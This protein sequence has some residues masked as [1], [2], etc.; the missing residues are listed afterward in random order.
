M[1]E[2]HLAD[3]ERGSSTGGES[4]QLNGSMLHVVG[5]ISMQAARVVESCTN[6]LE[7]NEDVA[8]LWQFVLVS[9]AV[10]YCDEHK[11]QLIKALEALQPVQVFLLVR[12]VV[13]Q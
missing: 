7:P 11:E 2:Q 8:R 4:A 9:F 12:F 6:D 5:S 10:F 13:S 3:A 1:M